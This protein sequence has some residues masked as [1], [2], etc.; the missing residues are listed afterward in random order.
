ML[1]SEFDSLLPEKL[2]EVNKPNGGLLPSKLRDQIEEQN[3]WVY[4]TINNGV[5]KAS[6]FS[7]LPV[8]RLTRKV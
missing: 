5:Y 3:Q 2:R 1:Y 6:H 7:A 8:D 4:D